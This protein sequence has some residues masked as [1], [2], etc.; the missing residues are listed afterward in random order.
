MISI[1]Y[2]QYPGV[3]LMV[4]RVSKVFLSSF[5]FRIQRSLSFSPSLFLTHTHTHTHTHNGMH[6]NFVFTIFVLSQSY[7]DYLLLIILYRTL[8]C[9]C[10]YHHFDHYIYMLYVIF[11][12]IVLL[13]LLL[14]CRKDIFFLN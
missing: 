7:P 12:L 5:A 10:L 1:Y 13:L 3:G 6:F 9:I 4:L 11:L 8:S 2:R 14:L